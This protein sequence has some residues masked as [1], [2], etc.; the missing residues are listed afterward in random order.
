MFKKVILSGSVDETRQFNKELTNYE[1]LPNKTVTLKKTADFN[2]QNCVVKQL[3]LGYNI[4]I[5]NTCAYVAQFRR[6]FRLY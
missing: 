2:R 1:R 6:E 4:C 3:R 5:I